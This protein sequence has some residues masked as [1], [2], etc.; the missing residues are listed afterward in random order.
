MVRFA[1]LLFVAFLLLTFSESIAQRGAKKL[2]T[3]CF[4]NKR[5]QA[6][7]KATKSIAIVVLLDKSGSMANKMKQTKIALSHLIVNLRPGD[8]FGLLSFDSTICDKFPLRPTLNK[9]KALK[10]LRSIVPQGGTHPHEAF[11]LAHNMLKKS[12]SPNKHILFMTDGHF[13][14]K[15][16]FRKIHSIV[17]SGI[18]ISTVSIGQ[19]TDAELLQRVAKVGKGCFYPA[20][21]P[22]VLDKRLEHE[23][24]WLGVIR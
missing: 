17:K 20:K 10:A 19:L 3:Q 7:G 2:S 11:A 12:T 22:D 4:S 5:V 23:L 15:N 13:S 21:N 1:T 14:R 16:F 18:S 9:E 8:T 6:K 24:R